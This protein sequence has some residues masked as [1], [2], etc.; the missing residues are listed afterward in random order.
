MFV[1]RI[2]HII[3][4]FVVPYLNFIKKITSVATHGHITIYIELF[5]KIGIL[6]YFNY[7]IGCA[8]GI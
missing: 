8:R 6:N 7:H 4:M 3:V 5:I 1:T 2:L